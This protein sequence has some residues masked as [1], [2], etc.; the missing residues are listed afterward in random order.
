MSAAILAVASPSYADPG[1]APANHAQETFPTVV[2]RIEIRGLD[3]TH[4]EVVRREVAFVEGDTVSRAQWDLAVARLWN[5][6]LFDHVEARLEQRDD[7]NVAVFSLAEKFTINPLFRF[8]SDGDVLWLQVGASDVNVAGRYQEVAV[9]YERFGSFQGGQVWWRDPRAFGQRLDLLVQADRL[10]R[11]RPGFVLARNRSRV[12]LNQIV[13]DDRLRYG[14]RVDGF[15][16]RFIEPTRTEPAIP[17]DLTGAY[18][19]PGVRVGRVDTVRLRMRGASLEVRPGVGLT[20]REP[21]GHYQQINAEGLAFLMLGERW[22]FALR[23]TAG[24]STDVPP[25]L[26]YFLGGL[27]LIR[28]YPDNHLRTH[29]YAA[30]NAEVRFVAFDSKYVAFMP[31]LFSDAAVAEA[32]ASTGVEDALSAGFG[33]RILI[34]YFVKTGV[35]ADLAFPLRGDE[36]ARPALGVYQFF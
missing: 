32:E 34:P 36:H 10:V 21:R 11:P 9:L 2:H 15:V 17:D 29:A 12:E 16:D 28:G 5:T 18:V 3:S 31:V 7:E 1:A 35:R 27:D 20:T 30:A 22:N 6:Q 19:D 8:A 33:L 26:R 24:S 25:H 4:V 13:W 23:A 14:V